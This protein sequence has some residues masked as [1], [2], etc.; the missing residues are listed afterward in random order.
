MRVIGG[1]DF[2][3]SAQAFGQDREMVLVRKP[4]DK[5]VGVPQSESG[6]APVDA[7]YLRLHPDGRSRYAESE[8]IDNRYG[9]FSFAPQVVWFAGRRYACVRV[10]G[11]RPG[12][13]AETAK[14]WV[15]WSA[16]ELR[17]FLATVGSGLVESSWGDK[18]LYEENVDEWFSREGSAAE[19]GWLIDNRVSIAISDC[20]KYDW[21]Y[22][23]WKNGRVWKIDTDGLKEMGFARVVTPWDAFQKLSMW[24]GG[25][26][27]H[28]GRPTVE[29]ESDKVRR[30]KHGFDNMSFKKPKASLAQA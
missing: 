11:Y 18:A 25:T 14:P 2:Y 12:E 16:N 8:K 21:G 19:I 22:S 3:D 5:A 10:E 6:L 13:T 9:R 20:P 28:P 1:H 7:A 15:A 17:E 24:I 30:D 29:I 4:W 26:I 27:A 23:Q